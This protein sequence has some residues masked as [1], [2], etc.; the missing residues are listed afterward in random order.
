M[1]LENNSPGSVMVITSREASP[2]RFP[3]FSPAGMSR[4]RVR[5]GTRAY[6]QAIMGVR[7]LMAVNRSRFRICPRMAC[8][9]PAGAGIWLD[10]GG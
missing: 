3:W 5:T 4:P 8:R 1:A 10:A 6:R 2:G 7:A 9:C